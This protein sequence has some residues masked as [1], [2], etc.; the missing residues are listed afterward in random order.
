M[1]D[2]DVAYAITEGREVINPRPWARPRSPASAASTIGF[3]SYS[4]GCHDDVNKMV[5]SRLGWDPN[6]DVVEIL[7]DYSRYFIGDQC[8]DAFAQ[9]L[10]GAG[11]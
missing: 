8:T 5:W 11:A 4:E 7:R 9:G 10:A 2:W 3:L 6:A 1:P